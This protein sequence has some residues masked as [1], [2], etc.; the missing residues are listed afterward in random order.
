M[1]SLIAC[2]AD[3]MLRGQLLPKSLMSR[4]GVF[5]DDDDAAGSALPTVVAPHGVKRKPSSSTSSHHHRNLL[6]QPLV[7]KVVKGKLRGSKHACKRHAT[8]KRVKPT[9]L[10]KKGG[11]RVGGDHRPLGKL[12]ANIKEV[13]GF[14]TRFAS[15]GKRHQPVLPW[16]ELAPCVATLFL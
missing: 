7:K 6:R 4:C 10:K 12:P 2:P 13:F 11:S 8:L 14:M 15:V 9:G 5:V 16:K 1:Q 3:R